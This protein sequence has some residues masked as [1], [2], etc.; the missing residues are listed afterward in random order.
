MTAFIWFPG[1]WSPG[2]SHTHQHVVG[3]NDQYHSR[4]SSSTGGL[5]SNDQRGACL[6]HARAQ[7]TWILEMQGHKACKRFTLR[8]LLSLQFLWLVFLCRLTSVLFVPAV[9]PHPKY[10][11]LTSRS[12][13]T[14][15]WR[16]SS[17]PK[18]PSQIFVVFLPP[19]SSL[20]LPGDQPPRSQH[21][22]SCS[23]H[24]IWLHSPS[25]LARSEV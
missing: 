7:F 13:L 5:Q 15:C 11:P 9:G 24:S 23:T 21:S 4:G 1:V 14:L 16:N 10:L 8:S 19:P 18:F 12:N 25:N 3:Q 6:S 17:I 20:L 2:S 22:T